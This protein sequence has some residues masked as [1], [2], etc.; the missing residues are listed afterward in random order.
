MT[1]GERE[2]S[3]G[4]DLNRDIPTNRWDQE[5]ILSDPKQVLY[6]LGFYHI[7]TRQNT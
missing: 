4:W 3:W 5:E 7:D 1:D 6:L 2:R